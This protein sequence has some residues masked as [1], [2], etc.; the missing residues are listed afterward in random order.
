[1]ALDRISLTDFRNHGSTE[2]G[3]TAQFNLLVGENGAG[4]TNSKSDG[5]KYPDENYAREIMQLFSI[6]LHKEDVIDVFHMTSL[7][8]QS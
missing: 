3:D 2:L 6:G 1:M 5:E 8:R 7:D 4:K